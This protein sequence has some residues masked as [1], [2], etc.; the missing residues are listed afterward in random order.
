MTSAS[1]LK[2][3]HKAIKSDLQIIY[4]SKKGVKADIFFDIVEL[5]GFSNVFLAENVFD[6]SFKTVQRYKKE[7]KALNPR[8]SEIALKLMQLFARGIEIFGS[9][10]SF[11][12][13]LEKPSIGL[14]DSIPLSFLNTN[15]G[16]NL[17]EEELIRIEYGA[18]A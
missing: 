16:I 4:S 5:S 12:N 17:I 7:K 6:I 13:W 15:T 8:D 1:I 11:V 2:K 9:T 18:L 14:A 10:S 3:Y